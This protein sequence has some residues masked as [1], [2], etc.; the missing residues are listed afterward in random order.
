MLGIVAGST[1]MAIT[2]QLGVWGWVP[3]ELYME[4]RDGCESIPHAYWDE[5]EMGSPNGILSVHGICS[6]LVGYVINYEQKTCDEQP[7]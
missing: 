1:V 5:N 4:Y 3:I 6:C 2:V 7:E